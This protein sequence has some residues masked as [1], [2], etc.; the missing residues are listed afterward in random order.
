MYK[1]S[2]NYSLIKA[3]KLKFYY[4]SLLTIISLLASFILDLFKIHKSSFGF[5]ILFFIFLIRN[6][7][8]YKDY[9]EEVEKN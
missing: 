9:L 4:I 2:R 5:L 8:V 1:K 3:K 6:H 7:F